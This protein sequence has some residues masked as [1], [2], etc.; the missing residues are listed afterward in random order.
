MSSDQRAYAQ[1]NGNNT[2]LIPTLYPDPLSFGD[3]SG[4]AVYTINIS[5]AHFVGG[6]YSVDL[7]YADI[8]GNLLNFDGEFRSITSGPES[9]AIPIICFAID[10]DT[11]ASV[12][13][14]FE[15]T[16]FFKNIPYD[17]FEGIPLLTIGIISAASLTGEAPPVPYILSPPFPPLAGSN[18][19]PNITF[20]SDGDNFNVFSSGP[21]GWLGLP[22]LS[23]ILGAYAAL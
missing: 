14:G 1:R 5:K 13:P 11:V 17:R 7:S 6:I 10:V 21:A 20:K 12:Y 2:Q 23:A 16:L 9:Q 22:A 4:C 3:I 19:S 18:I 8:A 15:F